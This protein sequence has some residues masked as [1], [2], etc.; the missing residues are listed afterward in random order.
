MT[1]TQPYC[2]MGHR[3][4]RTY[5]TAGLLTALALFASLAGAR[6]DTLAPA[7][8]EP[9]FSHVEDI[10]Q[11]IGQ[12]K[13]A[14]N[15]IPNP[16]WRDDAC[17]ACHAGVPDAKPPKLRGPG[18]DGLCGFCHDG[19]FDHSYIHSIGVKPDNAMVARMPPSY[20]DT[21]KGAD[22]KM[23]CVTCH[24]LLVQ[25]LSGRQYR[26]ESNPRFFRGG[27]FQTRTKQ[28]YFCHDAR[29]YER[30]NPHEQVGDDG[31]LR[32]ATCGL[33]HSDDVEFLQTA[34]GINGLHF[35]TGTNL[36]SMC[37]RCHQREPHPGGQFAFGPTTSYPNHLVKPPEAMYQRMR[38]RSEETGVIL[39]LEPGTGKVFCATCHEPHEAGVTKRIPPPQGEKIKS[40]LRASKMCLRCHE[41]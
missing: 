32:T 9:L 23:S 8:A 16:H 24:D 33:C 4:P 6:D 30:L 2:T 25:C 20:R 29:Q 13:L 34:R 27:P 3:R 37:T 7:S 11:L 1:L 41:K 12:G 15:Q 17:G 22:K 39:P 21:L 28:C 5:L 38:E 40:R 10:P 26:K 14:P 36:A 35:T 19:V 31:K 18:I